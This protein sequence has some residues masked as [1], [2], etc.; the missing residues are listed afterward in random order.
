[1]VFRQTVDQSEITRTEPAAPQSYTWYVKMLYNNS[2]TGDNVDANIWAELKNATNLFIPQDYSVI[3]ENTW[4]GSKNMRLY[5]NLDTG[6]TINL[7]DSVTRYATLYVDNAVNVENIE[8]LSPLVGAYGDPV[9][10]KV[11]VRNTGRVTDNYAVSQ[12]G[13]PDAWIQL[14]PDTYGYVNVDATLPAGNNVPLYIQAAGAYATDVDYVLATGE[15]P[16]VF[17]AYDTG[18]VTDNAAG[19]APWENYWLGDNAPIMVARKVGGGAVVAASWDGGASYYGSASYPSTINMDILLDI[20]FQWMKPGATNIIWYEGDSVYSGYKNTDADV[21]KLLDNLRAGAVPSGNSYTIDNQGLLRLDNLGSSTYDILV[22]NQQQ[23]GDKTLGGD[24]SLLWDNELDAISAWVAAGKGVIVMEVSDYQNYDYCR[25]SNAI[26]DNLGFGWWFQHDTINDAFHN[27]LAASYKPLVVRVAGNPIGDNYLVQT[28]VE[29]IL[30]YKC[31]TLIQR[32]TLGVNVTVS[33]S[34]NDAENGTTVTFDVTVTNNDNCWDNFQLT[35]SEDNAWG[36][37]ISPSYLVENA[38][39]SGSATIS[40]TIPAGASNGSVDHITVKATSFWD[41]TVSDNKTVTARCLIGRVELR[42]QNNNFVNLFNTIQSAIDNALPGYTVIAYTGTFTEN[43]YVNKENLKIRSLG[44]AGVTIIDAGGAENGVKIVADGVTFGGFTVTNGGLGIQL[45]YSNNNLIENNIAENNTWVGIELYFSDNNRIENNTCENNDYGIEL[46]YSDINIVSN[47]TAKND[48]YGIYLWDS[49]NNLIENNTAENN[50]YGINIRF[51]SNNNIAENNTAENNDYGFYIYESDNNH[52]Q[53]NTAGSNSFGIYLENSDNNTLDNNTCENNINFGIWLESSGGCVLDNNTCE[54]NVSYGI[55]V[56]DS[57][58]NTISNNTSENNHQHGI[59]LFH[60]DNNIIDNCILENNDHYGI[61]LSD[62]NNNLIQN[63]IS[64]NNGDS[65]IYLDKP[66][67][68]NLVVGCTAS[69]NTEYGIWLDFSENSIIENNTCENNNYG[70]YLG[71]SHNNTLENNTCDNN[72][73]GVYLDY[74]DNNTLIYNTLT[75]NDYGFYVYYSNNNQI[76]NNTILATTWSNF[77]SCPFLY[78]WNGTGMK[79][80]GDINGPGGLGYRVDMSMYGGGIGL[81][82][83]TGID[84]A[85]IDSSDLVP[86]NGSY[87]LE[88]AEDQDEITY[89]DNAELWVID[90]SPDVEVYSPEASLGTLTPYLY[91]PVI[92]TVRNPV[93]PISATDWKGNDILPVI[94]LPDGVYTEAEPLTDSFITLDLGDLSGASQIKL[95]YRGYTDFSPI[96]T[97]KAYPY[98]EVK[99]ALGEWELVSE[100]EHLG[101][102]AAMPKT[103]VIDITNWFKTNDYHLRLHTG[104]L[105]INVDWIAIDTSV[106]EPVNVTVLK[107]TSANLY[108]KGPNHTGFEYF[109]GNFTKYGDVLPLL[110]KA[111]DEFVI[112]RAGDSVELKFAAQPAPAGERDFM[113]VTDA[114]FKQPFVKYLLGSKISTVDPLPFHGMSNYPYPSSESY[115]SDAEHLAYLSEWNTREYGEGGAGMSLPYSDNNTVFGNT[116][117]GSYYGLLLDHETNTRI[118]NNT[119]SNTYD[120]IYLYYSLNC[121]VDSNIV[122]NN[123]DT[124]IYFASSENDNL[125]NNTCNNNSYGIYVSGDIDGNNRAR[126]IGNTIENNSDDGIYFDGGIYGN[127]LVQIGNN[128]ISNNGSDGIYFNYPISEDSR[129]MITGNTIDNNYDTGIYFNNNYIGPLSVIYDAYNN[130]LIS[131]DNNSISNNDYDGIYFGIEIYDNAM[132]EIIGNVINNNDDYGIDF[133]YEIYGTSNIWIENNIAS[134]NYYEGI[135][136]ESDIYDNSRIMVIGNICDNVYDSYGIDFDGYDI[137]G[138]CVITLENN[139]FSNN[140][141]EG[142]DIDSYIYENSQLSIIGNRIDNNWGYGI[143]FDYASIYGNSIVTIKNNSISNNDYEGIYFG[144]DI[145]EDSYVE[146]SGNRIDQNGDSGIYFYYEIYD[147]STVW[148][149]N[150]SISN[151]GIYG[152][153]GIYFDDGIYDAS[154]IWITR[155]KIDNNGHG[156]YI[157]GDVE[158]P[159]I[160]GANEIINNVEFD[161]GIHVESGYDTTGLLVGFNNIVGN[162]QSGNYGVF[163]GGLENLKAPYN[164]WGDASGPGGAGTGTGDTI[165]DGVIYRPWIPDNFKNVLEGFARGYISE[166]TNKVITLTLMNPFSSN[167]A[168]LPETVKINYDSTEN[169]GIVVTMFNSIGGA[170]IPQGLKVATFLDIRTLLE[171]MAENYQITFHYTDGDISGMDESSLKLYYWSSD[172]NSW[173]LCNNVTVDTAANTVSGSLGHLTPFGIFG[174]PAVAVPPK[175][176]INVSISPSKSSALPGNSLSYKVTVMNTGDATDTFDLSVHGGTGW[177]PSISQNSLTLDAGAS[178]EVTLMV[179]VPSWAGAGAS[180]TI[181]VTATSRA[182]PSVSSSASCKASSEAPAGSP[183][184]PTPTGMSWG[185]ILTLSGAILAIIILSS[186]ILFGA[187]RRRR[188]KK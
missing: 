129:V 12:V 45:W 26:L 64:E 134:N 70:I 13:G 63:C 72:Y 169:A 147:E 138:N 83:P 59:H 171:N 27:D 36:A 150:N 159:L 177:S 102:P 111:D 87:T 184:K 153:A 187:Y 71:N 75:G 80:L 142:I 58:N 4:L 93:A 101:I 155:N 137:Y 178:S 96:G 156:I 8:N 37:T 81:R 32:P 175:V 92:H 53:N 161:S 28:G 65:G 109:Y 120:G 128:S 125:T 29:N 108:Y 85:A 115:P 35:I 88:V 66:S 131:I 82:P 57:S 3:L 33:P 1:M 9:S 119:I 114:Y 10:L 185:A 136:F 48:Y 86:K 56:S 44:G 157:Y 43:L 118:L 42:D 124:G 104:T 34:E 154:T 100:T 77:G 163:N 22:L 148:I 117:T 143:D 167:L 54:N 164:W 68:N 94:V 152:S 149:D 168:Q 21:K 158:A 103:Y 110:Q 52:I 14:A 182:D 50:D 7:V 126:I 78:T 30:A 162:S 127:S 151:N 51:S 39:A 106:D 15:Q 84:Y 76:D 188:R 17:Q 23:L 74:S 179:K 160:I 99:N 2:G 5:E 79:F 181:T 11:C 123:S 20:T 89:L 38:S 139:S 130:S 176:G 98:A 61:F 105:K 145:Y 91:P 116:I 40:V 97:V 47:N 31:P 172:D 107:P 132:V 25:V 141:Y 95:I 166:G 49:Y 41:N 18:Y 67:D 133:G 46:G 55:F 135:D 121:L 16:I 60:S 6:Y 73:Y 165:S 24:P 122:E 112:M 180:S 69:N 174:V 90:H 170:Q 144:D 146:I 186:L 140:D 173:H 113:L 19:I 62:S 183:G